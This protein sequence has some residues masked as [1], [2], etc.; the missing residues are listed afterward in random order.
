M[1][2]FF[3][4]NINILAYLSQL[5]EEAMAM[6]P[7]VKY[8]RYVTS[9]KEQTGNIITFA[10]FEEGI[11]LSGTRDNKKSG[12]KSEEDST[13]A[14]L[15]SKEEM[16]AMDSGNDFDDEHMST[17]MLEDIFL[18]LVS[19]IRAEIGERHATRYVITLNKY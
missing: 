13:V 7:D 10:Q 2:S 18:T 19:I 5:Y 16:G 4:K 1:I 17:E 6:R 14:P 11:L 3:M 15:I 8:T 9:L 12:D